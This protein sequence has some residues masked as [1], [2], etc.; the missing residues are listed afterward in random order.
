MPNSQYAATALRELDF[1][2][3]RIP[4]AVWGPN[5]KID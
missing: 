3:R 5:W 2:P 4:G 1:V